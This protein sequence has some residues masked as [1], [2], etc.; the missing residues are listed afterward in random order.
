M[1]RILY[2]CYY[3]VI[4]PYDINFRVCGSKIKYR[5]YQQENARNDRKDSFDEQFRIIITQFKKSESSEKGRKNDTD[6][7]PCWTVPFSGL[8]SLFFK[9]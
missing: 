6:I 7:N 8:K 4:N 9:C 3:K 1:L 2:R 5:Q